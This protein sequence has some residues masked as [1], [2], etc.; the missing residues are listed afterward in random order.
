MSQSIWDG[1]Q[2][3]KSPD[4]T[5]LA[6]FNF[7]KAFDS[8]WHSALFH[9]LHLLKLPP[10]FVLWACSF[11]SGRRAKVQV[12]GSRSLSFRIRRG[13][14]RAPYWVQYSSS[15]FLMT[16]PRICL[17]VLMPP[18]MLTIW[19]FGPTPQT[20]SKYLLTFNSP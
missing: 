12:G 10:C 16:S 17:R 19:P 13:V 1:F 3:K 4:Q 6:S 5:I 20:R 14:P 9:K 15:Y 18:Y 7:S 8:V 11:L 2:K